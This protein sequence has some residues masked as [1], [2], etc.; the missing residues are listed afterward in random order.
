M[1]PFCY[2]YFNY[3]YSGPASDSVEKLVKLIKN[4]MRIARINFSHI[5]LKV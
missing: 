1:K 3:T 2:M 4:G 5:D